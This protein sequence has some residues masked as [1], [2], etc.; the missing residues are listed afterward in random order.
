MPE[1]ATTRT[2]RHNRIRAFRPE[3]AGSWSRPYDR[4]RDLPRLL[5]LL[6]ADL[7]VGSHQAHAR[8][9]EI[10]RRALRS[11]RA[12]ARERHWAYDPGR[13]AALVRAAR[14]EQASLGHWP[15]LDDRRRQ[16]E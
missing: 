8:L 16:R 14:A 15:A 3:R 9:L 4:A 6:T 5:P 1:P 13:H 2:T 10:L 7:D 12:R 11:E